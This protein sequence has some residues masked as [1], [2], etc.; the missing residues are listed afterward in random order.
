MHHHAKRFSALMPIIALGTRARN[1][2][3]YGLQGREGAKFGKG[4]R[5]SPARTNQQWYIPH[6]ARFCW[7][8]IPQLTLRLTLLTIYN[9]HQDNLWL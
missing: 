8:P 2:Q 7:S 5:S 6:N 3:L 1:S 4:G 9:S